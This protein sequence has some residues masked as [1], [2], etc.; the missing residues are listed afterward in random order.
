MISQN[1]LRAERD[2][3][4]AILRALA[5]RAKRAGGSPQLVALLESAAALAGAA[6]MDGY[7]AAIRIAGEQ[8][9]AEGLDHLFTVTTSATEQ[10]GTVSGAVEVPS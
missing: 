5:K 1:Q 9:K 10:P 8:A 7:G 2:Q 6:A 3:H 4:V